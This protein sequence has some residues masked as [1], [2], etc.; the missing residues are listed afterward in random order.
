[1]PHPED[2]YRNAA[3]DEVPGTTE[4]TGRYA[5][6][7]GLLQW[8][9]NQG[10][11]GAPRNCKRALQIG[12]AVHAMIEA[13]MRGYDDVGV[14]AEVPNILTTSEDLDPVEACYPAYLAW[15]G[16][17]DVQ[18]ISIEVSLVSELHQYGGTHDVIAMVDGRR[19]LL[20]FKTCKTARDDVYLNHKLNMAAH[21]RLW[22]EHCPDQPIQEYH[23]INLPKDG[24]PF[25]AHVF[26]DLECEWLQFWLQLQ[27]FN[28][29][30]AQKDAQKAQKAGARKKAKTVAPSPKSRLT[31]AAPAPVARSAVHPTL[32]TPEQMARTAAALRVYASGT[33]YPTIPI[34]PVSRWGEQENP[35]ADN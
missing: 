9:Y 11:D 14:W 35:H 21:A 28:V 3:G 32:A 13:H 20:D 24:T 6:K 23:L 4:V 10:R 16:R 26:G 8:K 19:A 7:E 33:H 22:A 18:P 30:R 27:C 34:L 17:H 29:E 5:D 12:T 1:M 31:T 15:R 25:A 2:G